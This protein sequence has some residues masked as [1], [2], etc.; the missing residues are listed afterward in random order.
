M[1]PRES[2]LGCRV[3]QTDRWYSS[4]RLGWLCRNYVELALLSVEWVEGEV[5]DAFD[6]CVGGCVEAKR[7]LLDGIV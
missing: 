1:A 5:H 4:Q 2:S 7:S 6:C 3:T